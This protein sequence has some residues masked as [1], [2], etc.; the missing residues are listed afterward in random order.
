M[1][2]DELSQWRHSDMDLRDTRFG[3]VPAKLKRGICNRLRFASNS[4]AML[5]TS[6]TKGSKGKR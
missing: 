3:F 2:R 6:K 1:E 4:Y 5:R